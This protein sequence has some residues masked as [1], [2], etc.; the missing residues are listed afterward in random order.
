MT[1]DKATEQTTNS[2]NRQTKFLEFYTKQSQ[3][4]FSTYTQEQP[5]PRSSSALSANGVKDMN[6]IPTFHALIN[7]INAQFMCIQ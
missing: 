2:R 3:A 1:K 7:H 5:P 4:K 6:S